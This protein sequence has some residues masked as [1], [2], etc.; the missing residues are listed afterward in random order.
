MK[1]QMSINKKEHNI[2]HKKHMQL[3]DETD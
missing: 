1:M 3:D 2:M